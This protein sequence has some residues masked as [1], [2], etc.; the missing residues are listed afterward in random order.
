MLEF[1]VGKASPHLR[2]SSHNYDG[3]TDPVLTSFQV[4]WCLEPGDRSGSP[5]LV[6]FG[7]WAKEMLAWVRAKVICLFG[8]HL[9]MAYWCL[10]YTCISL[11]IGANVSPTMSVWDWTTLHA[12]SADATSANSCKPL[13]HTF[14]FVCVWGATDMN[15]YVFQ[16]F[17][18]RTPSRQKWNRLPMVGF[19]RS[20][21][22]TVNFVR[23]ATWLNTVF[24][25]SCANVQKSLA[26]PA[27]VGR[28]DEQTLTV[29]FNSAQ[30][31]QLC[32][33]LSFE[34]HLNFQNETN[35]RQRV[36]S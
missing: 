3:T 24:I 29:L 4:F 27:W 17:K 22:S 11:N 19:G 8:R 9:N 10:E 36:K 34:K 32:W 31:W 5:R 21:L 30:L 6:S 35:Y 18:E 2:F 13:Q 23:C 16:S 28:S 7:R 26:S 12:R 1:G 25:S 33:K 14:A 15:W 20:T